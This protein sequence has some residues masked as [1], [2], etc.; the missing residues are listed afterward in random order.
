MK[1]VPERLENFQ[2]F[3]AA[4]QI[5]LSL[6]HLMALVAIAQEYERPGEVYYFTTAI[7]N[8]IADEAV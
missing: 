5:R 6:A 3:H 1:S 8:L 2:R 4:G 7:L